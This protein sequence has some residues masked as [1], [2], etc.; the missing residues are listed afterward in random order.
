MR[1]KQRAA[2]GALL[3]AAVIVSSA[4]PGA[5]GTRGSEA[6]PMITIER[7][8]ANNQMNDS[9]LEFV[10]MRCAALFLVFSNA[11][12]SHDRNLATNLA[13]NSSDFFL[14]AEKLEER[15]TGRPRPA[16]GEGA[17]F[18]QIAMMGKVYTQ[19]ALEAKARTGSFSDDPVIKSDGIVCRSLIGH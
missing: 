9:T 10:S 16:F 13:K 6:V 2:Q 12:S 19:L 7:Y 17:V 8:M 15:I 4:V 18:Q 1:L 14:K 3:I 11:A 5:T